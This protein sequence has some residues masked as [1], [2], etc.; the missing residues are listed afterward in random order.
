MVG[1]GGGKKIESEASELKRKRKRG[2]EPRKTDAARMV[3]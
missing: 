1:K 2:K 3:G